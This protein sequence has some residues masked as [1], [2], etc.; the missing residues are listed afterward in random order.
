M[1]VVNSEQEAEVLRSLYFNYRP[2]NVKELLWNVSSEE[3][4][5]TS[6]EI[7]ETSEEINETSEEINKTSEE[8]FE[9]S[10]EGNPHE[11]TEPPTPE[12][13]PTPQ[14][15]NATVHIGFHDIFIEGEYLT[16][17]SK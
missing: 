17:C 5:E 8:I 1:A 14:P 2:A 6:E 4:I 16:L 11:G 3:I 7:N 9:S 13:T 10:E 15:A 12:T